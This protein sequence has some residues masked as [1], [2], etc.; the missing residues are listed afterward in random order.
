VPPSKYR[1][2]PAYDD[3]LLQVCRLVAAP[4]PLDIRQLVV[5]SQSIAAAHEAADGQ[6]PTVEDLLAIYRLD[7]VVANPEPRRVLIFDDVLTAGTHYRAIH[8]VLSRR[9]P[10]AVIR[11]LFVARRVFPP[12]F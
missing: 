8:S 10:E 2:D 1:G 3:R 6:R 5:Q 4:R 7:E 11:A 9:F 12:A